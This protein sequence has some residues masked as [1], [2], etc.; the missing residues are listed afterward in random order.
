MSNENKESAG[1][2]ATEA[3]KHSESAEATAPKVKTV[4]KPKPKGKAKT[5]SGG[6]SA[7]KAV[8]L[9]ACK[10]HD[11]EQVWVT[12]DGQVFPQESDAKAHAKN[13][14]SNETLKVSAK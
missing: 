2:P 5:E 13:L 7:L 6:T 11:L 1:A 8:G 12:V 14:Q 9:A 4:T 10:R 3:L